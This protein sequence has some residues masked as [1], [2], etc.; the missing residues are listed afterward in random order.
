M[1]R[2]S[3]PNGTRV[4]AI[5][6]IHG[7]IDSLWRMRDLIV[8]HAEKNPIER[9]VFISLGDY[10]DRGP[11]SND[12]IDFLLNATEHFPDFEI[13]T[14]RGNHEQ[15]PLDFLDVPS[16]I[17]LWLQNGA[18]NT[19]LSYGVDARNYVISYLDKDGNVHETLDLPNLHAAFNEAFPLDHYN[20]CAH[21][22]LYHI[23]GNYLF[24]HAGVD[25][26]LPPQEQSAHTLTW[27][28]HGWHDTDLEYSHRVVHGHIVKK[29]PDVRTYRV[30][31]DT[32]AYYTGVL[33][34]ATI[35]GSDLTFLQTEPRDEKKK[36][37]SERVILL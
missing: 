2:F 3:V 36:S 12:V 27:A 31:T 8:D 28:Y 11:S 25:T 29:K 34:C 23:E 4:Y 22:P 14:L 7:D 5:G 33:T 16:S 15:M 9:K 26:E 24:C 6:D 19:L 30:G 37:H 10:V 13:V 17:Y 20:L 35:E 32:N 1:N 18:Y 21:S